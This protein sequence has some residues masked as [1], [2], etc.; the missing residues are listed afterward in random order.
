MII[1]GAVSIIVSRKIKYSI[2]MNNGIITPILQGGLGNRLFQLSSVYGISKTTGFIFSLNKEYNYSNN[3]HSTIDYTKNIFIKFPMIDR[4][5]VYQEIKENYQQLFDPNLVVLKKNSNYL[6]NGYFQNNKYF[7]KYR[8]DILDLISIPRKPLKYMF[9]IHFRFG[10]FKDH[11]SLYIDYR[12]YYLNSIIYIYNK[13]EV[14]PKFLII[15][16]DNTKT[17]KY[18]KYIQTF[19][20]IQYEFINPGLDEIEILSEMASC[21]YGAI[22]P[23][24]TFSWWGSY[25]NKNKR[26]IICIPSK[27]VNQEFTSFTNEISIRKWYYE[28]VVVIPF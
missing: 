12:K 21:H 17:L 1:I 3:I 19:V 2:P 4:K 25:L 13:F 20:P 15:S 22:I 28:N 26:R 6:M 24:S 18:I 14:R 10:D 8:S 7:H 5:I 16:D 9:F 23:N 11:N 27:L